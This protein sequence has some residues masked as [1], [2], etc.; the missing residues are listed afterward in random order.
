M[1]IHLVVS[2]LLILFLFAHAWARD[3][4]VVT[5]I[6]PLKEFGQ[7]VSGER[8]K[9]VLLLP[10]G[11]EPHTWEPK[12]SDIVNVSQAD[13]FIYVSKEMEPWVPDFVNS[14]KNENLEVL[15]ASEFLPE[16]TGQGTLAHDDNEQ[17]PGRDKASERAYRDPHI[18]LDFSYDQI[19]VDTIA[20]VL[21]AMDPEGATYYKKNAEEYNGKL[22]ALDEQYRGTLTRCERKEIFL[23]S[24]AA[25]A[26]LV[27]RYGLQQIALYGFSPNAEPTPRK[28]V[29][30][31]RLAKEHHAQAIYFE[32]LV[33]DKL[34]KTIAR[35]VGARA[36]VLNPGA[37]LTRAQIK[38]GVTFLSLME[39]N[40]ENLR[41]GLSCQ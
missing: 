7:A 5:T 21:A 29:E 40:L 33:S 39:Q 14:V 17:N 3:L 32:E 23:G 20:T 8:A 2:L 36:L 38:A 11:S 13:L 35:E 41:D 6:F 31:V 24:H 16:S 9:V 18:W 4:L 22:R 34:A 19:I 37:N 10:P 26:F 30:I 27:E 15:V 25:F 1:A 28:M 12:P